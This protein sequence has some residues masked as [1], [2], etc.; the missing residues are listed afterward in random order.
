MRG[1]PT[2]NPLR[3]AILCIVATAFAQTPFTDPRDG[4]TYKTAKIGEQVWLAE[5]LNY[6][7]KG[8]KCY[9]N[10]PE[11]CEKY[12]RLYNWDMAIYVC[13]SG[14]HL[15][16][17]SEYETF[18]KDFSALPGGYGYFD[19][20]FKNI[21]KIGYW[22]SDDDRNS[23]I[24]YFRFKPYDSDSTYWYDYDKSYLFSVRCVKDKPQGEMK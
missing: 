21:G 3:F 11:N 20:S 15:P 2:A 1:N 13:P 24:A 10:K 16:S 4:K 14:W 18:D 7:A 6:N 12:G 5:N 9:D 23:Y 17:K 19:G 8:S 22:W